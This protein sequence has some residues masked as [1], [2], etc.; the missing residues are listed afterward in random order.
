MGGVGVGCWA[1]IGHCG[2]LRPFFILGV[3]WGEYHDLQPLRLYRLVN[4]LPKERAR[5]WDAATEEVPKLSSL[6]VVK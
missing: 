3:M 4:G 2:P 5:C 6:Q 1:L